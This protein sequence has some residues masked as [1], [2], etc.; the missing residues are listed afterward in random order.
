M[1]IDQDILIDAFFEISNKIDKQAVGN[2]KFFSYFN[3]IDPQLPSLLDYFQALLN[4]QNPTRQQLQ[5]RGKVLEQIACLVFSK[6]SGCT[7]VKSFQSAGPQYDLIVSGDDLKWKFIVES[8]FIPFEKRDILIEA[9]VRNQRLPDK[10]FARLCS[11]ME[12]NL[13][14]T[15]LGVFL[16]LQGATG[17]PKNSQSR[18]RGVSDCLLRQIIF[19]AK[20]GKYI[21]VLDKQD[22]FSLAQPGS[23]L[24]LLS[25]KIRELQQLSGLPTQPIQNLNEIDLP[26]YLE[27]IL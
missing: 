26:D 11:I 1:S 21:V 9:K 17:F 24:L 2:I 15:G 6:L 8:L 3:P 18:I 22:I 25:R 23:L 12:H 13:T 4:V 7:I 19:H 5:E 27:N 20:T 16:T 14:S 10:D